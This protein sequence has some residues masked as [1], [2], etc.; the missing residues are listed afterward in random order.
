MTVFGCFFPICCWCEI[1]SFI[2]QSQKPTFNCSVHKQRLLVSVSK[3]FHNIW[4][5]KQKSEGEFQCVNITNSSLTCSDL[6]DCLCDILKT[7]SNQNCF[8]SNNRI[9]SDSISP[10][11]DSLSLALINA[12]NSRSSSMLIS[13]NK[14]LADLHAPSTSPPMSS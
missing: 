5:F 3:C 13:S 10:P 4:W 9:H 2:F 1:L 6:N 12:S 8:R 11:F 14:S 7:N